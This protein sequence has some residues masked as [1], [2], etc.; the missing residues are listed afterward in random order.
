MKDFNI[1]LIYFI[2]VSIIYYYNFNIDKRAHDHVAHHSP[3][4]YHGAT[5]GCVK[6]YMHL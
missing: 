3:M 5:R 2:L 4:Y 1:Y 6:D